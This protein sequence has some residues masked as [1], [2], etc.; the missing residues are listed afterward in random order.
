MIAL[1]AAAENATGV[2]GFVA[3]NSTA[4]WSE[5]E[6]IMRGVFPNQSHDI[7]E[8]ED[9]LSMI[10]QLSSYDPKLWQEQEMLQPVL[11]T[12]GAL[13]QTLSASLNT[14]FC[15]E[16]SMSNVSQIIFPD[17]GHVVTDGMLFE[18][19]GFI[20]KHTKPRK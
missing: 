12:N 18:V 14:Q 3:M 16:Y 13:D 5:Y 1:G 6:K 15:Q 17:A 20:E 7:L 9:F 8:R 4:Q 19:L 10:A 2:D 11:L